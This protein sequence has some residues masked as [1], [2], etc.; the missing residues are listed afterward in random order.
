M[1]EIK[2]CFMQDINELDKLEPLKKL[3]ELSLIGNGV[4]IGR[5]YFSFIAAA[6]LRVN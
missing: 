2:Y 6:F 4:C 1:R 5:V 3:T